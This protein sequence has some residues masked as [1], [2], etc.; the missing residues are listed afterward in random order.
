MPEEINRLV[1]D[2]LADLLLTPSEDADQNLLKEGVP[3]HKIK[4]VGNVMIDSLVFNLEKAR[5]TKF[6]A[7]YG[8]KEKDYAFVTLHR[9][10]NVDDKDSFS[11]HY[12]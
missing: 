2:T 12:E 5:S 8:L 11:G 4:R 1:T 9:P 10:S 7:A 3:A 6:H